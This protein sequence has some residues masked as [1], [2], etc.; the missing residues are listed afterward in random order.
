MGSGADVTETASSLE[1]V[2]ACPASEAL[3]RVVDAGA[4]RDRDRGTVIHRFLQRVM[5]GMPEDVALAL[6]PEKDQA[7]CGRIRVPRITSGISWDLRCEVA[8]A[9]SPGEDRA[10]ILGLDL[11]RN[12]PDL[13]PGEIAGTND[14]EGMRM[15][16]VPVVGDVKTGNDV[17]P[18]EDNPQAQFHARARQLVTGAD[19]VEAR[20]VYVRPS[21]YVER[22]EHVFSRIELETFEDRVIEA[23]Q[24]A[25]RARLAV[26]NGEVPVVT[27]GSWCRYCPAMPACPAYAGLARRFVPDLEEIPGQLAMLSP[28]QQGEAWLK[29]KQIKRLAETAEDALKAL[30]RQSPLP[31]PNGKVIRPVTIHRNDFSKDA[32]LALLAEKGATEDEI[33]GCYRKNDVEQIKEGKANA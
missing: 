15:D 12:Y 30:A 7:V 1:R 19:E 29:V 27:T 31:L 22:D 23:R 11:D 32:A 9:L 13:D 3:P 8:Y 2:I 26:V 25:H 14:F 6:V 33:A 16:G 28:A 17:T 21:G 18:C 5:T 24:V 4:R 20:I 10:R